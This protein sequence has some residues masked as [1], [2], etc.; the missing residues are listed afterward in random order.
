MTTH[1]LG[2][3]EDASQAPFN[4]LVVR[5]RHARAGRKGDSGETGK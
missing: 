5:S 1:L 2:A 4:V 3:S